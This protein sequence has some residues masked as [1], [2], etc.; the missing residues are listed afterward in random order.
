MSTVVG[1]RP[2]TTMEAETTHANTASVR[3]LQPGSGDY[4]VPVRG[5]Q[6]LETLDWAKSTIQML[7]EEPFE[8]ESLRASLPELLLLGS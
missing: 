7:R 8:A 6:P 5:V 4:V 1:P 2:P 3:G